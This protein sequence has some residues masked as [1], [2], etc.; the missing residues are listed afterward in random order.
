[1]ATLSDLKKYKAG[2]DSEMLDYE[3]ECFIHIAK[4]D[5]KE[6][7]VTS[8]IKTTTDYLLKNPD[9][10]P[11]RHYLKGDEVVHLEGTIPI[12]CLRL[13][14]PSKSDDM[15]YLSRVIS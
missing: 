15:N 11:K 2:E 12:S 5:P 3:K 10:T 13:K 9:F 7:Y 1:M 6:I 4:D 8:S 14:N